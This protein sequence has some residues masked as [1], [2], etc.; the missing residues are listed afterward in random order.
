MDN[1]NM[2]LK[3]HKNSLKEELEKYLKYK[4]WFILSLIVAITSAYLYIR[5]ATPLYQANTI[6]QIVEEKSSP[7]ELSLFSDLNLLPGGSKKVEDEIEVLRSRTNVRE[8]VKN[9]GLDKKVM[10]VGR[11]KN[12]EIYGK[13]PVKVYVDSVVRDVKFSCYISPLNQTKFLYWTDENEEQ[14]ERTFGDEIITERGKI[15]I[16]PEDSKNLKPYIKEKLLIVISPIDDVTSSYQ[17]G[18][19]TTLADEYSSIINLTIQSPVQQKGMDFLNELIN[20]YNLNGK[21]DKK[22]IADRTAEFIDARIADIYSDL[23]EADQSAEDFKAG[24]GIADI[25]SQSN[26]NLNVSAANQ[27]ELQDAQIQLQIAN[28]V[29]DEL[30]SQEGYGILPSNIGLADPSIINTTAIYNQKVLERER[31][32]KSSNEK[33]PVIVNIDRQLENLKKSMQ[34]SLNSM[35]NNLNLRVNNLSSQLATI[36][37]KIYSAPRNERALREITRKQQTVEGLYLYLLQ[38]REEAQIAYAS[39]SPNSKIVDSAFPASKFPVAPKKSIIYLASFLLGLLVPAGIIY[40]LDIMDDKIHSAHTLEKLVS[41][42]GVPVIGELPRLKSK[43]VKTVAK[44]DRSVLSEALRIIRTNMDYLLKIES[45]NESLKNII[46]VSSSLPREGKTF[47]S[48]NLALILSS[49][50]KKILLVGADIRNPKFYLFF[51]NGKESV[52]DQKADFKNS[53]GL[54]D[55]LF[56]ENLGLKDIISTNELNNNTVDVIHSGKTFPNPSELLMSERFGSL[57][58]AASLQYDYV[59]VDTAPMMPVTDT[60]LISEYANLLIYVTKAG[61]TS[62]G[63][64]EFPLKLRKE[65]KI[66]HLAFVVNGVKTSELGYGGKYGYGYGTKARKWWHF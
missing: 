40:A 28:S 3:S 50:G 29:S 49:T 9:L 60:Q 52:I 53:A 38:K 22:I 44:E 19:G 35:T 7:S 18:L 20:I 31:L 57:M 66:N 39:A 55:Y 14:Q 34:S 1:P 37:S 15:T 61:K 46:Y 47:F 17:K 25:Q 21:N 42:A 56:D 63:D 16:F 33:N 11:V 45:K 27:Q 13:V 4:Y 32:L 51:N 6:I 12:S 58:K 8:V 54:T 36:N 5:Y 41:S 2:N 24:R 48:T 62:V 59:I 10:H 23:S 65:G 30:E 64:V 26:I 43:S